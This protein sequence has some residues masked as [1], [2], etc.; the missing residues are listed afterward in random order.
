MVRMTVSTS[1]DQAIKYFYKAFKH[2][3]YYT[4]GNEVV[5]IWGGKGAELLGLS[6]PVESKDYVAL[7]HN[8]Y[9]GTQDQIT[10]RMKANRNVGMDITFDV[11]K[12]V[13][14]LHAIGGDERIT[15]V[16]QEAARETLLAVIEPRMLT[17]VRKDG[18]SDDTR[19]TEN[20]CWAEFMH[21]D[22]RPEDGWADP[23]SHLH[24]F[25]FN[26]TYDPVEQRFKAG[27]FID[28]K[29]NAPLCQSYYHDLLAKKLQA[30]GY[31]TE[32][33]GIAFEIVG[34]P[35]SANERFSRRTKVITQVK[36]ALGITDPDEA[37]KL[38]AATRKRKNHNM[39]RKELHAKRLSVMPPE[40]LA[41]VQETVR[42]SIERAE[43]MA[44]EKIVN[45]NTAA[46][47]KRDLSDQLGSRK[48]V[49]SADVVMAASK[50]VATSPAPKGQT[51]QFVAGKVGEV[52]L[53][54]AAS[55]AI[56][57]PLV[58]SSPATSDLG[59]PTKAEEL[60]IEYARL[61][62]FHKA[63]VIKEA[64]FLA[65]VLVF[66][67][68]NVDVPRV[69]T[70]MRERADLIRI[71][72]GGKLMYTTQE[73]LDEE[74][75]IVAWTKAGFGTV[76]PLARDYEI[77][78][79]WL[80][81]EQKASIQHILT[82]NDRVTAVTG[83]SGA[84]KT[85][86]MKIAIGALEDRHHNVL[87]LTP[88][89]KTAYEVLPKEGFKK[90]DTVHQYLNNKMLQK[91]HRG[92]V[93]WVDEAGQLSTRD[94]Y[95]LLKLADDH[96]V[97]VILSGDT[98]QHGSVERG[99][100]LRILQEFAGLKSVQMG[101]IQRQKGR[102]KEAVEHLSEGRVMEGLKVID[103]LGWVC[104]ISNEERYMQLAKDYLAAVDD[105]VS[106]LVISPT[107]SECRKVTEQI[108]SELKA[109]GK[110]HDE[111]V[112][113]TLQPIDLTDAQLRDARTYRPG[114]VIEMIKSAPG[115]K[116]GERLEVIRTSS[117][118][119]GTVVA[120][121]AN[122]TEVDIPVHQIGDRYRL[123]E[124]QEILV[125]VG[126]PI[127]I[128]KNGWSID[129]HKYRLHNGSL[130]T[131]VGFTPEGD[132]KLDSGVTLSKDFAHITH[133]YATTSHAA[134]G[135]TVDRVFIAES[136]ESFGAASMEQ[137]YVAISRG[138]FY[139]RLYTNDKD[140]LFY[141][142][143]KTSQRMAALELVNQ[144]NPL[145]LDH[146]AELHNAQQRAERLVPPEPPAENL[147]W[148]LGQE[149][150]PPAELRKKDIQ[151]GM[152]M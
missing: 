150:K 112:L 35:E 83:K 49:P 102:Y 77:Q 9:P 143:Q 107:H 151:L 70:S 89:A 146:E 67:C 57:F 66:G 73:F 4:Q 136:A 84:G 100:A 32:T 1:A 138:R 145:P 88:R 115:L 19:P 47:Q 41:A 122:G 34:V 97:R 120:K 98:R 104:E 39:S 45:E 152:E 147:R 68:G 99:D 148:K 110:I 80:S 10:P 26:I 40:E 86:L 12:S 103:S 131:I 63:S 44:K 81:V 87:I 124:K 3:D 17:R 24:C 127:R 42:A 15:G 118:L 14:I 56:P 8:R 90:I 6:G 119:R 18:V 125:G 94:M 109:R 25:V 92:G 128:T 85:T 144:P 5:G 111:R 141:V 52:Q 79:D 78:E 123:Y 59:M 105:G 36:E 101:Q 121:R 69:L 139:C 91:E 129:D 50:A 74:K 149:K 76:P 58:L 93:I 116:S 126:E 46:P 55:S 114:F 16:M 130:R 27:S 64:D 113:Q 48:N 2:G 133:G 11:P 108:R 132:L 134:Q 82:S 28:M 7:C 13:S 38:G 60:A 140:E 53:V 96:H 51:H 137:M 142:A 72:Y 54:Q 61:H 29:E 106:A 37:A 65:N 31:I 135:Q 30:L 117:E 43:Q 33:K 23:H 62:S 20:I 75:A 21:L 22:A 95:R 71:E